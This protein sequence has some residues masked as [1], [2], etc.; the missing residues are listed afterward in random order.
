M[1][2][3]IIVHS[4][5]GNT[6][7]VA[8]KLKE[9]L[10]KA[11]NTVSLEKIRI[12]GGEQKDLQ[13]FEI[14]YAPNAHPYDA[15]VFAAP[16]RAFQASPVIVTYLNSLPALSG[17]KCALLVTQHFPYAWMGGNN[18]LKKMKSLCEQK[19]AVVC[20][21]GIVNWSNKKREQMIIDRVEVIQNGLTKMES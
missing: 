5:T 16:V 10:E 20:A 4:F 14:E 13:Q 3:G 15:V 18:A 2:I 12:A 7:F 9:K 11:G 19:G 1:N 8:E 21:A 17:K 6:L